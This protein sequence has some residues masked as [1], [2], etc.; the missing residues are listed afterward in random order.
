LTGHFSSIAPPFADRVLSR[1][2]TWSASGDK[3]ENQKRRV[4]TISLGRLQC[5]RRN[6][7]PQREEEKEDAKEKKFNEQLMRIL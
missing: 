7:A 4:S 3:R 2:L 1:R 6:S 5:V